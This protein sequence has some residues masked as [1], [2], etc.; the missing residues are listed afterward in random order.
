VKAFTLSD[1]NQYFSARSL[2]TVRSADCI[3]VI[4][5]GQVVEKGPHEELL[6]NP[7]GVYS[8][9]ISR[10]LD[11]QHQ[12]N[13]GCS[14]VIDESSALEESHDGDGRSLLSLSRTRYDEEEEEEEE[15]DESRESETKE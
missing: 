15:V 4:K 9:L 1:D 12:L 5:S 8:G 10:Q 13:N 2:S 7:D 3:Y 14:S 6:R 11:S